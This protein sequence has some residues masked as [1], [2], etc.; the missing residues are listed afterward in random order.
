MNRNVADEGDVVQ[1]KK[2]VLVIVGRCDGT[3]VESGMVGFKVCV[4]ECDSLFRAGDTEV[5]V[6]RMF[7]PHLGDVDQSEIVVG[8]VDTS[9][10]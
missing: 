3:T 10:N 1:I 2:N 6:C 4:G 9:W 7:R 5:G 8:R